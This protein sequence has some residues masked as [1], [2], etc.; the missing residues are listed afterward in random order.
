VSLR[1]QGRRG[2]ITP[3]VACGLSAITL[4]AA[5]G[6]SSQVGGPIDFGRD[7]QPILKEH[8]IRCHGSEEQKNGFRL[9]RRSR[10]YQGVLRPN[11][12]PGS[13]ATSRL[14]QRV[15][16]STIGTQMPPDEPL[17]REK[18]AVLQAWID[19]GAAWPD[20][21]ANE[22][23]WPAADPRAVRLNDAIRARNARSAGEILDREPD[24]IKGGGPDGSMP[25]M[26]AALYGD[27]GLLRRLVSMGADVNAV[28]HAGMTPLM[29]A[30]DDLDK[31]RLLLEHGADP[32][33]VSDAQRS[34][35][36]L[37]AGQKGGAS[38]VKALLDA[39]AEAKQ[40]ALTAAANSG[41]LDAVRLL[42]AAG[43][44]DNGDASIA[45]LRSNSMECFDAIG[46]AQPA[47]RL[48]NALQL[49]LPPNGSGREDAIRIALDRGDDINTRSPKGL[50]PLMRVA[51]ADAPAAS[52]RLLLARGAEP[53]VRTPDGKTALDYAALAGRT[54]AVALLAA[55]LPSAPAPP[56]APLVYVANNA[57][58][59]A[60]RRSL[61][62]L[63]RSG[64]IFY[65]R[66]G[67]VSCHSNLLTAMTVAAAR[68][69]KFVVDEETARS[70]ADTLAKDVRNT[71]DLAIQ[72][73]FMPG[74][75]AATTGYILMG[76]AAQGHKPDEFTDALVRLL[77]RS[78]RRDGRWQIA[79]RPPSE[80][81]EFTAAAVAIRGLQLFGETTPGSPDRRAIESAVAWLGTS[82]PVT[83]EDR[84]FRLF[85][86][87]WGG[88]PRTV[89]GVAAAELRAAQ[90]S[91]GGWAQ[92]TSLG[93]DAYS[94][95]SA[96]A[97]L[98]ESGVSVS[99]P[100]YRRGVKYLLETQLPDGSWFVRKRAHPTQVFFESGFPHGVDQYISAAATNW[101]TIALLLSRGARL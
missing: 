62:L 99:D 54:P 45:A 64:G 73:M 36:Q 4:A 37:A 50:T 17:P 51:I 9:D 16:G 97:A 93:S 10:A 33:A 29:W 28:N 96:L 5:P 53:G 8:C 35:L 43:A 80:S 21:F 47:L 90:R 18:V 71:R 83:T 65:K 70:E 20:G 38:L 78:Q 98:R 89:V 24:A 88:A 12:I 46:A 39:G 74:G 58:D 77:R 57:A 82:R 25:L 40:P 63:Q 13:S 23:E 32:N 100:A 41:N 84:V 11:I 86:L 92:L 14:Y 66:A 34:V 94:T 30:L 27:P 79:F 1:T 31:V 69:A 22:T 91:D 6:Q 67:C 68:A 7:V 87:A 72:G 61:P 44:I 2:W 75:G 76:L 56:P 60:I 3:V 95:G 85:G 42:L 55:S 49:L 15:S 59:A 26:Y 101:A 52:L 19:Q 81:S 48:K